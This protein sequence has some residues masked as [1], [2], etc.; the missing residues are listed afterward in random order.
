MNKILGF[1]EL[2]RIQTTYTEKQFLKKCKATLSLYPKDFVGRRDGYRNDFMW[3]TG[4]LA[5]NKCLVTQKFY[6]GA[7]QVIGTMEN[8]LPGVLKQQSELD[9]DFVIVGN[10]ISCKSGDGGVVDRMVIV[11]V[12]KGE[13]I[14]QQSKRIERLECNLFKLLNCVLSGDH[15]SAKAISD[16]I[17]AEYEPNDLQLNN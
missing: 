13:A 10:E 6:I 12:K 2:A 11:P 17:M 3:M 8:N 9:S 1:M 16:N 5:K 7:A 15:L 14:D 4:K